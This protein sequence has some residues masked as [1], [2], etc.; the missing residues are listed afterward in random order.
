MSGI[1]KKVV[2]GDPLK[3]PASTYNAFI[4][5]AEANRRRA[6]DVQRGA[7]TAEVK[8]GQVLVLND[9]GNDCDRFGVLDGPDFDANR[10]RGNVSKSRDCSR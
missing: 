4:D 5:V 10:K 3:I 2:D 9:S 6:L 1:L 8:P 7:A